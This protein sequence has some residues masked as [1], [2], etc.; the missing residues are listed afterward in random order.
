MTSNY[1]KVKEEEGAIKYS[2]RSPEGNP[3]D[4]YGYILVYNPEARWDHKPSQRSN[5]KYFFTRMYIPIELAEE[6]RIFEGLKSLNKFKNRKNHKIGT[7][8]WFI[9]Y[10][11]EVPM[12]DAIRMMRTLRWQ[13]RWSDY[14]EILR[15]GMRSIYWFD[16]D[17]NKQPPDHILFKKSP[18]SKRKIKNTRRL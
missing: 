3:H 18:K 13:N 2:F 17:S 1:E 15:D 6:I 8:E 12:V 10:Y 11:F 14:R 9:E 5:N 4:G 7:T 16:P